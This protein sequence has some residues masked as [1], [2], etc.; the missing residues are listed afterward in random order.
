MFNEEMKMFNE[1]DLT[2]RAKDTE[3]LSNIISQI[4]LS[5]KDAPKCLKLQINIMDAH[6]N[7]NKTI[8]K[9]LKKYV[10][11]DSEAA[12]DIKTLKAILEYI[13]LVEAG[14][15]R[16]FDETEGVKE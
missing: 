7:L 16:F 12:E 13:K 1:E 14:V 9:C 15:R 8:F 5:D 10:T 6:R 4:V 2:K 11:P 3:M